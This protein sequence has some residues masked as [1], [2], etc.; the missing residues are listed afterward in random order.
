MDNQSEVIQQQMEETRSALQ[1]KLETLEQ[2]VKNTVQD[3]TD[4]VSD[5][6]ETVK[7]AVQ[8]TV[9]T[10]KETVQDTVQ[11]VK[12]TF[13]LGKQVEAH[14]W[15]MVLGA[16]A[17]GFVAT[18]WLTPAKVPFY[19]PL[20]SSEPPPP[21]AP[22]PAGHGHNGNGASS[23]AKARKQQVAAPPQESWFAKHYQKELEKVQGLAVGAVGGLVRELLVS[24]ATPALA[25][26]IKDVVNS[27]TEK[28]GGQVIDGPILQSSASEEGTTNATL[29]ECGDSPGMRRSMGMGHR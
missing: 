16:T 5:T 15:A 26:Q 8:E 2:Q 27:I 9:G 7:E 10:V 11:S 14:P 6:V 22:Q 12:R 1:D 13:D 18:R 21:V 3:A 20:V 25:E 17:L 28:M 29:A 24:S 23:R 4:A 19:Q